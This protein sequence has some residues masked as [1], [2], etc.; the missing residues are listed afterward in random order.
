MKV[1]IRFNLS[2]GKDISEETAEKLNTVAIKI[3]I[4][5]RG[6]EIV[7]LDAVKLT[8][9]SEKH[10]EITNEIY[11]RIDKV[12]KDA[13]FD[14]AVIAFGADYC[15]SDE[16]EESDEVAADLEEKEKDTFDEFFDKLEKEDKKEDE[17]VSGDVSD[18]KKAFDEKVGKSG[19][20]GDKADMAAESSDELNDSFGSDDNDEGSLNE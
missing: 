10:I 9:Y 6:M 2:E 5:L 7:H 12:L 4:I 15:D 11:D 3:G 18:M 13:G 19:L 16:T 1:L 8:F 14:D 20:Y 17:T